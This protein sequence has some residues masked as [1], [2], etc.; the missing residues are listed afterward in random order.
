MVEK[1][2]VTLSLDKDIVDKI[3][4]ELSTRE[5]LSGAVE[6]SLESL[7]ASILL[8]KIASQMGLLREILSPREILKMRVKGAKAEDVVREMR[9]GA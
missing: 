4:R 6:K 1:T 2:K 3:R 8:E 9:N 7:S 5:T